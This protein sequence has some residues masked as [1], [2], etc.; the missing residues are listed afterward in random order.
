[1][2]PHSCKPSICASTEYVTTFRVLQLFLRIIQL[3]PDYEGIELGIGESLLIKAIAE[4]TGRSLATIKADLKR[5]GDL[6]LV[7]MVRNKAGR[8][9][10][11]LTRINPAEFEEQP[12]DDLQTKTPQRS[13]CVFKTQRNCVEFRTLGTDTSI[14]AWRKLTSCL[15]A[16]KESICHHEGA[17][18]LSRLRSKV[19]CAEFGGKAA[20][21]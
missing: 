15:V 10:L 18:S 1:M 19:Y 8:C 2:L 6:G 4:S 9:W 13:F 12:E 21:R 17:S 3:S 20:Y 5:E 16:S 14:S 11:R 7:A